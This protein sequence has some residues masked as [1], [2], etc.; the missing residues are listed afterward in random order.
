MKK[1]TKIFAFA[2]ALMMVFALQVPVSAAEKGAVQ[3]V[4]QEQAQATVQADTY[5]HRVYSL[6]YNQ[7]MKKCPV[8][9]QVTSNSSNY[10]TYE[11]Q[12]LDHTKKK[13]IAQDD[14]ALYAF[15]DL[16]K[17]QLYYYRV[18][19][20]AYDYTQKKYVPVSDWSYG[21][22][23]N[24]A[25]CKVKL[26]GKKIKIKVPKVKGVKKFTL[27]MSTKSD[28]GYKK[29][30]K[31]KPGKTVVISKFKNKAFKNGKYYYYNVVSKKN[32]TRLKH[33]FHIYTRY[34]RR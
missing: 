3:A 2:M 13:V 31:V 1:F 25:I 12:L 24:T 6:Y 9:I 21:Y 5:T 14:C 26:S 19:A 15:F 23:I 17:N 28:K 11:V 34:V 10:Y 27:Y 33:N 20:T 16:K 30:K 7:S 32:E 29:V 18:R 4:N 8:T 22:G